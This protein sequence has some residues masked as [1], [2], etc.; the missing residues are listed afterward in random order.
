[1]K[2]RFLPVW[3]RMSY[4]S[5]NYFTW[6]KVRER[7]PQAEQDSCTLLEEVS[8]IHLASVFSITVVPLPLNRTV[9]FLEYDYF[10]ASQIYLP[11]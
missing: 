9:L 2:Q 3:Q 4:C 1:M 6:S 10:L 7:E 5:A 8:R 11:M